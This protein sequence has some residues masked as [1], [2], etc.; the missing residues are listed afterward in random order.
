MGETSGSESLMTHRNIR[1]DTKTGVDVLLRD[2]CGSDLLTDH[3]VSG[4]KET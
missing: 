2:E 3:T 4:V 1:D